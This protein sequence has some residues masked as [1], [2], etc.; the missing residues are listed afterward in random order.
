[1]CSSDLLKMEN[2][3]RELGMKEAERA[4]RLERAGTA[5]RQLEERAEMLRR[6]DALDEDVR[7]FLQD[8]V[9]CP[10]CGS[11]T[12]PYAGG[13]LPDSAATRQQLFDAAQELKTL[14]DEAVAHQALSVELDEKILSTGR[15][16][17]EVV[18]GS[19]TII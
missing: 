4:S 16:E 1:M 12:H 14:E 15:D 19:S 2:E 7:A 9:P 6:V 18:P 13:I 8:G 17:E 3:R 11:L 5:L 10:L